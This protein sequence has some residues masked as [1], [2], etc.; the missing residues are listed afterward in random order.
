MTAM[1]NEGGATHLILD[2]SLLAQID[3]LARRLGI[4][5]VGEDRVARKRQ[6]VVRRLLLMWDSRGGCGACLPVSHE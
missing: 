3:A 4:Q 5:A 1:G 2:A 6:E